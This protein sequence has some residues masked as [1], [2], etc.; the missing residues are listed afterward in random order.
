MEE[1]VIPSAHELDYMLR[2][3]ESAA[4]IRKRPDLFLWSQGQL[5][6]LLPHQL[7]VCLQFD[8]NDDV[9]HSECLHGAVLDAEQILQATRLAA[10]LVEQCRLRQQLPCMIAPAAPSAHNAAWH[11][12]LPDIAALA[13]GNV[14]VH[15]TGRMFCGASAV[16]LFGMPAT[17]A[18]RHK[19][20]I[21]LL[22]PY[23]HLALQKLVP[24]AAVRAAAA[25]PLLPNPLTG[26]ELEILR[27][28]PKGMINDEIGDALGISA[29][30]VKN[31]VH[32]IYRK[33]NVSNRMQAVSLGI[34]LA[35]IELPY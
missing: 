32:N 7:M 30:T 8:T 20:F 3:A 4:A 15:G 9:I 23:L 1:L 13:P 28:L 10:R 16:V 31:H 26:R 27:S 25:P 35:L 33:L 5:Q 6:S 21:D 12:L 29:R 11:G 34:A 17:P 22:L 14:L 19:Y 18:S 2:S 24:M